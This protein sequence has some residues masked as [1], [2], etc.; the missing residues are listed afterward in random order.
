MN[1]NLQFQSTRGAHTGFYRARHHGHDG[2]EYGGQNV[3]NW[4]NE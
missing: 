1:E 2:N 3:E 4:P